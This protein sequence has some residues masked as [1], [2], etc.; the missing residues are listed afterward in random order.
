MQIDESSDIITVN[1]ENIGYKEHIFIMLNK[2]AGVICATRD[3]LTPTVIGLIPQE[4]RRRELFPA[5]RLDKDTRGFVLITD[6]GSFA[7]EILSP[8]RHV[9]K[10]YEVWLESPLSS[11]TVER[12]AQ[13]ITIDGGEECL[14]AKLI[15]I[16]ERFARIIICEGKY[17][18]IKRM[19]EAVGNKVTGLRRIRIGGLY[20][21]DSLP[22][23]QCRELSDEETA[24][25][26]SKEIK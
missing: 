22:E 1:G 19:F 11:G 16:E 14:P 10:E 18:Q 8:R 26:R 7:H 12:F 3:K 5:G 2:P 17:H 21:D 6:D 20:L 23:G 13:G 15:P 25:I 24:L 4:L 9:E